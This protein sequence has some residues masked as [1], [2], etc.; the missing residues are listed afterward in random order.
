M[1]GAIVFTGLALGVEY[2]GLARCASLIS[3]LI[4]MCM[5]ESY[6]VPFEKESAELLDV[7]YKELSES[8][9]YEKDDTA[10]NKN[11]VVVPVAGDYVPPKPPQ[12]QAD[13]DKMCA[14]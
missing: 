6:K 5:P 3:D 1:P 11:K 4:R 7:I 10:K 12:P 13:L 8:G 9:R 2:A 14:D